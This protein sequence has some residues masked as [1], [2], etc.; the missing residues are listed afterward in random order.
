MNIVLKMKEYE[1]HKLVCI[2]KEGLKLDISEDE[3]QKTLK[4]KF[5]QLC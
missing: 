1:S 5:D 4:A 3:H 2:T